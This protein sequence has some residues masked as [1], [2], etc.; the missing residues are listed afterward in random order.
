MKIWSRRHSDC[1]QVICEQAAALPDYYPP[2]LRVVRT[3][4]RAWVKEV[5]EQAGVVQ[6]NGEVALTLMYQTEDEKGLCSYHTT[7]PFS[8]SFS[9][10]EG[11]SGCAE[12]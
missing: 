11:C 9:L 8:H 10:P 12:A 4:G 5:R 6:V 3:T 2:I 7:A 1:A